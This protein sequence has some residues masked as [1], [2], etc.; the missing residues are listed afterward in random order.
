M[1]NTEVLSD[2]V[3]VPKMTGSSNTNPNENVIFPQNN[4]NKVFRPLY[5][6]ARIIGLLPFSI[7]CNANGD[8]QCAHVG[9]FDLLWFILSLSAYSFL[10]WFY[11]K[12]LS[13]S[14]ELFDNLG[15][16]VVCSNMIHT[17]QLSSQIIAI[18]SDMCNR[19]QIIDIL[20]MFANFDNEVRLNNYHFNSILYLLRELY[21]QTNLVGK[22]T[23]EVDIY[24]ILLHA[25]AIDLILKV[26]FI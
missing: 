13:L 12:N 7:I 16:Y 9:A 18:V 11:H 3:T 15:V 6:I 14:N 24:F 2:E 17:L 23:G 19:S 25:F 1:K 21:S 8:I 20:K 22:I 4:F 26:F 5:F 10:L